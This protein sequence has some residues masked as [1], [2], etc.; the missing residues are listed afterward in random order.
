MRQ[1]GRLTVLVVE[2]IMQLDDKGVQVVASASLQDRLLRPRVDEFAMSEDLY[3]IASEKML[4]TEIVR[5]IDV[6]VAS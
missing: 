1:N 5:R 3:R 6:H 4:W 2:G